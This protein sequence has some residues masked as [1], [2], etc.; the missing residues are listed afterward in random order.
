MESSNGFQLENGFHSPF[1]LLQIAPPPT[2]LQD[3]EYHWRKVKQFYAKDTNEQKVHIQDTNIPSHLNGM[4]EILTTEAQK[5]GQDQ[6]CLQFLLSNRPMDLLTELAQADSPPGMRGA[7]LSWTRRFLTN[8]R[9]VP[10]DD[11]SVYQPVLKLLSQIVAVE[12]VVVTAYEKEEVLFL[13]SLSAAILKSPETYLNVFVDKHYEFT[14][15]CFTNKTPQ[16]NSLFDAIVVELPASVEQNILLPASSVPHEKSEE[17]VPSASS[18]LNNFKCHCDSA[19]QFLVLSALVKYLNSPSHEIVIKACEGILIL[20]SLDECHLHCNSIVHSL[21]N[22]IDVLTEKLCHT[23]SRIPDDMD[24]MDIDVELESISW[25]LNIFD[26][27]ERGFVGK[28]PLLQ[29]L[30]WLDYFDCVGRELKADR[31][32]KYATF[33]FQVELLQGHVQEDV[34]NGRNAPKIMLLTKIFKQVRTE[35][36]HKQ[37]VTWLLN[38]MGTVFNTLLENATDNPCIVVETLSLVEL[39]VDQPNLPALDC[40]VLSYLEK[41]A[42]FNHQTVQSWSDEEDER[43]RRRGSHGETVKSKTLAP[44]NILKV[45]NNFLLLLPKQI[46]GDCAGTGYEEYVQDASRHYR[47]WVE[48]TNGFE[49]PIEAVSPRRKI[50]PQRTEEKASESTSATKQDDS[51][52]SGIAEEVFYEG[53]LLR[54]LFHYI[55]NMVQQPYEVNL[56]VI[57]ILSKLAFLPHPYLHEVLL[58]PEVPILPGVNTL[59]TSVQEATRQI[60]AQ[61]PLIE[62]FKAKIE[63]TGRRLLLQGAVELE[64]SEAA[65]KEEVEA[66]PLLESVIVLEEFAKELAAIAF[67]KFHYATE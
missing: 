66:D 27:E 15:K 43:E 22:F 58:N 40:L 30:C 49:W 44:N 4:L 21:E 7:V 12:P 26:G 24:P 42:Y 47:G 61:V 14:I 37:C 1:L 62:D 17:T 67:V 52:D 60:L 20:I 19:G 32:N 64:N 50:V 59:W 53:P 35:R 56:A 10:L 65:D 46:L 57:A 8:V 51:N 33:K 16:K 6:E 25:G 41:R 63:A 2:P 36:V 28:L 23:Y 45:I 18:P 5:E 39:F 9:N 31:V 54:M 38:D 55:R 34:C 11:P 48:R 13:V 29:F 3:F